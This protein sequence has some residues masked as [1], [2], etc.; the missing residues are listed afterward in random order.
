M[1]NIFLTFFNLSINAGWLVLAII[2]LRFIL[3]KAPKWVYCVLWSIVGIRL[4]L[5]FSLESIFSLLPSKQ[6]IAPYELYEMSP[7]VDSGFDTVNEIINPVFSQVLAS[8]PENS[9][10]PLQVITIIASYIWIIGIVAMCMYTLFTYIS[11]KRR[12]A[13]A[14]MLSDNVLQSENVSSPFILGI[15]KPRIYLPYAIEEKDAEY[16]IA[17]EKAH[18]RRKDHL[19][20]PFAFLL[21]SV[22][23]FN[24]L[25]WL[26]YVLLCRDIELAC[27]EKVVKD[28]RKEECKEYSYAL[29]NCSI[30]RKNIAACPLAFGEVGVKDRVRNVLNYKKPAFWIIL[31]GILVCIVTAVCFLTVPKGVTLAE[32]YLYEPMSVKTDRL[33]ITTPENT[34]VFTDASQIEDL[35]ELINGITVDKN[36]TEEIEHPS[37]SLPEP[38]YVIKALLGDVQTFELC[39]SSDFKNIWKSEDGQC[40]YLFTSRDADKVRSIFTEKLAMASIRQQ[41]E[42]LTSELLIEYF[43]NPQVRDSVFTTESHYVIKESISYTSDNKFNL[44]VSIKLIMIY[45]CSAFRNQETTAKKEWAAQGVCEFNFDIKDGRVIYKDITEHVR[46][47]GAHL[48]DF[49]STEKIDKQL[50]EDVLKKAE[51]HFGIGITVNEEASLPHGDLQEDGKENLTEN[52]IDID[53]DIVPVKLEGQEALHPEKLEDSIRIKSFNSSHL[54]RNSNKSFKEKHCLIYKEDNYENLISDYGL[55]MDMNEKAEGLASLDEIINKYSEIQN[56]KDLYIIYIPDQSGEKLYEV[57]DFK[58]TDGYMT[59][60]LSSYPAKRTYTGYTGYLAVIYADKDTDAIFSDFTA[61][62]KS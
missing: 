23:W 41:T 8:S 51:R 29:L 5:P 31:V 21:L 47:A 10:N 18:L 16:V 7:T 35:R 9:V 61:I 2:L 33:E 42:K 34:Y 40:Q 45:N 28:Y 38:S 3:K 4:V 22:Y 36:K 6:F 57:T 53:Y 19:I 39:V 48:A 62:I 56:E 44:P 20:K 27:D 17:H 55:C 25:M 32:G 58:Y 46:G 52:V 15:L 14:T 37:K 54:I 11:L 59:A 49:G 13:T 43:S 1:E 30:N 26:A 50:E 12:V 60:V 24:P